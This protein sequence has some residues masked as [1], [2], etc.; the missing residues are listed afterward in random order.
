MADGLARSAQLHTKKTN[1]VPGFT[2]S[3][4]RSTRLHE[5]DAQ[6]GEG[7]LGSA[8]RRALR[9]C[10]ERLRQQRLPGRLLLAR[11]PARV[12]QGSGRWRA[13]AQQ[14][15]SSLRRMR[16]AVAVHACTSQPASRSQACAG[17]LRRRHTECLKGREVGELLWASRA[18]AV[19]RPCCWGAHMHRVIMAV[20]P[21][22]VVRRAIM[23]GTCPPHM[24]PVRD[25]CAACKICE[26]GV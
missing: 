23:P 11:M 14:H 2:D 1:Q 19:G 9:V 16:A 6:V 13:R 21:S 22:R 12:L 17:S 15:G 25:W 26:Q 4:E 7:V 5:L 18:P 8:P 20:L 10:R 24:N 3:Q